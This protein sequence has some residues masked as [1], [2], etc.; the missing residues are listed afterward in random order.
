M[1]VIW[2]KREGEMVPNNVDRVV[3][4]FWVVQVGM[5]WANQVRR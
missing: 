4:L 1:R 2:R 3:G 5:A